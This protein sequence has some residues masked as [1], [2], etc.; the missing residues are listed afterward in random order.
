MEIKSRKVVYECPIF[1]VEEREVVTHS[2]ADRIFWV[3]VRPPNVQTIALTNDKKIVL[4]KEKL[5]ETDK[6]CILLPGGKVE[7]YEFTQ[8]DVKKQALVE[9]RE[10]A[11]FS[12]KNCELLFIDESPWNTM[13]R[14][15]YKYVAWDLEEGEQNLEEG[16]SIEPYLVSVDEAEEIIKE[17]RMT[18]PEEERALERAIT[19]F[20]EKKLI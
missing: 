2:G 9:L 4:I 16:E 1:K 10:E 3:V 6:E 11:G 13:D 5:G 7:T 18:S 8:D 12:A 20:K 14:D 17:R 15:F 19:F